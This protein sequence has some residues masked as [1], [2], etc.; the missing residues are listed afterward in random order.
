MRPA[1]QG[2]MV[3]GRP[4]PSGR[5]PLIAARIVRAR[6]PAVD[7]LATGDSGNTLSLRHHGANN[8]LRTPGRSSA[9]RP[10]R[11]ESSRQKDP[12]DPRIIHSGQ[13]GATPRPCSLLP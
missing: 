12:R 8:L 11:D 13:I 5:Y 4:C 9:A 3:V 7:C 2:P 6:P 1:P 10:C